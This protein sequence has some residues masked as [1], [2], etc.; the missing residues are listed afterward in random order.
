MENRRNKKRDENFGRGK[1][2]DFF[3]NLSKLVASENISL[4]KVYQAV[5]DL[6]PSA[7]QYPEI[8]CAKL[9]VNDYIFNT[10]NFQE[11][12]WH[13]ACEITI[14]GINIGSLV[15]GYL[16]QKPD[17]D[18]GP[19]L[20]QE[21]ELLHL[22]C[23][24]I[25]QATKR[26]EIKSL[27]QASDIKYRTLVDEVNEGIYICDREG[28]FIYANR[29]LAK[30]LG[31]DQPY[32][33]IGKKFFEFLPPDRL[34]ELT[35]QFRKSLETGKSATLITT[36]I[37][38]HG[39]IIGTI[40][41]KPVTY[42]ADGMIMGSQGV[43]H[44]ITARTLAEEKIKYESTHDGLTGLYNR[45]FFEAEMK[46]LE[47]G[48]QFPV[49]IVVVHVNHAHLKNKGED[50]DPTVK[51]L[52]QTGHMLFGSYRGDDIVA[53]V[54][55]SDFAILLPNVDKNGVEVTV[56]RIQQSLQEHK[57]GEDE[58]DVKIYIGAGTAEKGVPLSTALDQ[59]QSIVRLGKKKDEPA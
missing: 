49:S 33:L 10:N 7:W 52:K 50:T 29:A 58:H 5:I 40:E 51:K 26:F 23:E 54:G 36:K 45:S 6:I 15:V 20:V 31:C 32:E 25:S 24:W 35:S 18:E 22:I 27:N 41:I 39:G 13:Q 59:A 46:R 57:A 2:C 3:Y 17:A 37:L 38:K 53:R 4:R 47:R 1:A 11:S 8:T 16:Q 9:V 21:K 30:T 28:T 42:I 43:V 56:A 14:D 34:K 44:D 19:F 48:R 12:E 55:E